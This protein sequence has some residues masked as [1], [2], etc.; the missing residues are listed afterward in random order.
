MTHN[1]IL[2]R[3]TSQVIPGWLLCVWQDATC[4]LH[5]LQ[6]QASP[7]SVQQRPGPQSAPHLPKKPSAWDLLHW[8]LTQLSFTLSLRLF[9]E[10][11]TL[12]LEKRCL[13][14]WFMFSQGIGWWSPQLYREVTPKMNWECQGG[15]GVSRASEDTCK[16]AVARKYLWWA[17]TGY[18]T[19]ELHSARKV[20][21][22]FPFWPAWPWVVTTE[23]GN[24]SNGLV[25]TVCF[26]MSLRPKG[27]TA[28]CFSPFQLFSFPLHTLELN[29]A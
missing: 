23:C 12:E 26:V 18:W 2:E 15:P 28:L 14:L 24:S 21:G 4:S 11:R 6:I 8:T 19:L 3:R 20:P 27:C 7:S 29:I 16:S 5:M 13:K 10:E 1:L 9:L 22:S 25:F 17:Q